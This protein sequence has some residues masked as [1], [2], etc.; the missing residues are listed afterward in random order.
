MISVLILTLNEEMNLPGCLESVK[1]CDDIVVYDSYSTDRTIEIARAEGARVFQRNFDNYAN[2]RNAALTDVEY[3]YSWLLMLDADE[4]ATL[5]VEQEIRRIVESG[6]KRTTLYR[7][8][9]KDMFWGKW[10]RRSSGYPT[11]FG[12][13]FR[14]GKVRVEREINEEYHTDGEIGHLQEHLIHYPFKKG[15]AFWIKRHNRYSTMEA[16]SLIQEIR[17]PLELKKIFVSDPTIRRKILKQMAY[18][19]PGRPFFVF[20]YLYLIRLGFIDGKPGLTYCILRSIYEY[21]IDVKVKELRRRENGLS[22]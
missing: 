5:A 14:N 17:K 11:W 10:L 7:I 4:R 18:R 21:M 8:R 20:I 6:E 19:M 9:R 22:V 13:F 2:Q 3:K 12:R 1:W 16:Q 15:M